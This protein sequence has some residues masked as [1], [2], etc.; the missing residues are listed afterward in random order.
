MDD[1]VDVRTRPRVASQLLRDQLVVRDTTIVR[2][3]GV[4]IPPALDQRC[5]LPW[6]VEDLFADLAR[7]LTDPTAGVAPVQYDAAYGFPRAYSVFHGGSSSGFGRVV[8]ESFAPTPNVRWNCP[9]ICGGGGCAAAF[10]GIRPQL[11]FSR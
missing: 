11:N 5:P 8:V 2:R 9:A 7:A 4:P 3:D 1:C 10:Y 6:R